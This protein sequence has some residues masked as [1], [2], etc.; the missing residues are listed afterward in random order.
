ML[1]QIKE[2]GK[3]WSAISKMFSG[4]RTQHMIKNRYNSLLKKWKKNN[5]RLSEDQLVKK[6]LQNVKRKMNKKHK[7]EENLTL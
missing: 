6:M 2:L 5:W 1:S 4:R 3:K 7:T